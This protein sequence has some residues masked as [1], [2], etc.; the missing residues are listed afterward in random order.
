MASAIEGIGTLAGSSASLPKTQGSNKLGKDEF[1]KLL[2]TQLQHQ[3]PLEPTDN[4][5]FIAQLATFASVEQAEAMNE[6]LDSLL[7][8]QT[9]G[10]QTGVANLVG[11]DI[12]YRTNSVALATDAPAVIQGQLSTP[13]TQVNAV[14]TDQNGKV[15]RTLTMTNAPAGTVSLPWDGRD[16]AGAKLPPGTY[17]VQLTAADPS[18]ADIPIESRG[19]GRATGVTFQSGFPELIINGVHV[20]LSDV[21][22][23]NEPPTSQRS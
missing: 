3:D 17:S 19:L 22:E 10:N 16:S 2:V 23:I 21:V 15:V 1:L 7:M 5:A 4:Q 20:R 11:K 14:I 12:I 13:A 9:A 6:R 18:G 8:A